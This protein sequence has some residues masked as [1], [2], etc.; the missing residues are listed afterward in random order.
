MYS[1]P[2]NANIRGNEDD[3]GETLRGPLDFIFTSYDP[4]SQNMDLLSR[5]SP[6]L[7]RVQVFLLIELYPTRACDHVSSRR[8]NTGHALPKSSCGM[9]P[10]CRNERSS[11]NRSSRGN[12][13]SDDLTFMTCAS[14]NTPSDRAVE[15]LAC[16]GRLPG[17]FRCN[18]SGLREC[19]VTVIVSRPVRTIRN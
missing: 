13:C 8:I 4:A 14:G 12:N 2:L 3:I 5:R 11:S 18:F 9:D 16:A 15:L 1:L 6:G 17:Q 19:I 10:A 7:N